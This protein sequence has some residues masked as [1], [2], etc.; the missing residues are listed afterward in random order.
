MGD[1]RQGSKRTKNSNAP[2]SCLKTW[3]L[4]V[5]SSSEVG[6]GVDILENKDI[7]GGYQEDIRKQSPI[8]TGRISDS[9][10]ISRST[11]HGPRPT[12]LKSEYPAAS[13]QQPQYCPYWGSH[14]SPKSRRRRRT[15]RDGPVGGYFAQLRNWVHYTRT[16]ERSRSANNAIGMRNGGGLKES[17]E[18][19][20]RLECLI[21]NIYWYPFNDSRPKR[22]QQSSLWRAQRS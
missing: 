1:N 7:L 10:L 17:L 5:L 19:R 6:Q 14:G 15:R 2:T 22:R 11:H 16:E 8:A 13:W 3:W 18:L 4:R 20:F 21:F 9:T 12:G